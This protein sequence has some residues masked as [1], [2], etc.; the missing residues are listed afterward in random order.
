MSKDTDGLRFSTS[1]RR[2]NRF[3]PMF[4]GS[5]NVIPAWYGATTEGGAVFETVFHGIRPSDRAPRVQ[6]NE[7]GDRF[8]APVVT[9]RALTLVDL[10]SSGLHAI[11][12]S[13]E[14][15]IESRS[16]RYAWT[17]EI[18]ERLRRGAPDSDGFAWVS[19]AHDTS[20]CVV[21]YDLPGRDTM[22]NAHPTELASALGIG[23]G[24]RL[25]REL[26][27]TARITLVLPSSP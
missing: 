8:L 3:S 22:I 14:R 25:L 21:L 16:N 23:P 4:D 26:A 9:V 12:L 15:L 13:R 18:A 1:T 5:G 2:R 6:P 24:V 27:V 7:Y 19:R 11:G 20:Q 10:T 17:N